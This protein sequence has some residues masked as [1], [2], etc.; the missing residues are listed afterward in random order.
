MRVAAKAKVDE[1]GSEIARDFIDTVRVT[2]DTKVLHK[3]VVH[4]ITEYSL[5]V[6]TINAGSIW[7]VARSVVGSA[8]CGRNRQTT[9]GNTEPRLVIRR[10]D[11]WQR[12]KVT[13]E[14]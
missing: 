9:P 2:D 13:N 3:L 14:F 5:R 6:S 11:N 10:L 4:I 1:P 7:Q 8:S 12:D